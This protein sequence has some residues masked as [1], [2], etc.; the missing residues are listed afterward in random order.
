VKAIVREKYGPPEVLQVQEVEKPAPKDDE[1]LV[2]VHAASLNAADWHLLS[3]KPLLVRLFGFGFWSPKNKT[4]GSDFAGRVESVGRS[5]KQFQPNDEVFGNRLGSLAEY[6][7]VGEVALVPKP[8]NVSFEQA[9][10]APLAGITALQGLRNQGHIQPGKKVLIHG[11]SGGVGTSAVQIAKAFGAEV[12]AVCS[13][14]NLD[15]ARSMG[16]DHVIDYTKEDFGQGAQRYDLILVVNGH[17]PL[18]AY[19]R[20]LGPGGICVLIG[21]EGLAQIF[22]GKIAWP[23]VSGGRGKRFCTMLARVNLEDLGFIKELLQTGKLVPV[24][25]KRYPLTQVVEA[26]RY[27][28]AG[29]AQGKLVVMVEPDGPPGS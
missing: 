26:I 25:E 22:F 18:S 27:L 4:L 6:L 28:E 2:R 23:L 29:H 9:A 20:A 13:T 1:V 11:A 17:H 3:G 8:A 15:R 10:A 7:S 16:A 19:K 5:V 21:G 12:T 24:I 14:R